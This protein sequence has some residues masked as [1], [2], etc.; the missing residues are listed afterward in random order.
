MPDDRRVVRVVNY[1]VIFEF[2]S[3]S[4]VGRIPHP[5]VLHRRHVVYVEYDVE[6]LPAVFGSDGYRGTVIDERGVHEKFS[7]VGGVGR[8]TVACTVFRAR[9]AYGLSVDR[10]RIEIISR[11][12][13]HGDTESVVIA[14]S[15]RRIIGIISAGTGFVRYFILF[16]GVR[17]VN[18][19]VARHVIDRVRAHAGTVVRSKPRR[20]GNER[21]APAVHGY[22][23]GNNF[24]AFR[25]HESYGEL[26]VETQSYIFAV[27]IGTSYQR[28]CSKID[29]ARIGIEFP[30]DFAVNVFVDDGARH[31]AEREG[32]AVAVGNTVR[33]VI[34]SAE[35]DVVTFPFD[36]KYYVN[37]G[38]HV[39]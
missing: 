16:Y 14:Q 38:T 15:G 29:T 37:V 2:Q 7:T 1:T 4:A 24:V 13:E 21:S 22:G 33:S 39:I 18:G 25:R 5:S 10:H 32:I 28:A 35:S 27:R 11:I 9:G 34:I 31:R 3:Q 8:V 36:G 23:H 12:G 17:D 6:I 19:H 20:I 26:V 30:L